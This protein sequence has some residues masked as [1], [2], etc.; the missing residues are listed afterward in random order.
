MSFSFS[1]PL[2][3]FSDVFGCVLRSEPL[4]PPPAPPPESLS[5]PTPPEPPDPPDPQI[6]RSFDESL[7]Q[8]PWMTSLPLLPAKF[9]NSI[10]LLLLD[11]SLFAIWFG[12]LDAR[13]YPTTSTTAIFGVH[14]YLADAL[15]FSPQMF[16]STLIALMRSLTAVCRFCL[17][18]AWIEIVSWQLRLRSLFQFNRPV[19]RVHRSFHSSHL[20]FME[21]FILLTTSL[22]FSGSVTR[23][24]VIKT[25]LL[26]AEAKIVV[27]DYSRSA[28][29]GCLALSTREALF[30]PLCC[31]EV[32]K[33]H[34]A[35]RASC[36]CSLG[37]TFTSYDCTI[38]ASF[39]AIGAFVASA[40]VAEALAL[41]SA[42]LSAAG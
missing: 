40:L 38:T 27:H 41:C 10:G 42:L 26:D 36:L 31:L 21:L 6:C 12:E 33:F 2:S 18:L 19:D 1:W 9:L 17:D 11:E 20:S 32:F 8:P 7:A 15:T 28:F 35:G 4:R 29:A 22:V 24:I 25:V 14:C 23:S 16:L 34:V 3:S 5:P 39:S 30:P 13:L 37:W